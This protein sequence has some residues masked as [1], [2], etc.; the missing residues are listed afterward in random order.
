M[1]SN[2]PD[3]GGN[4]MKTLLAVL[5]AAA[6]AAGCASQNGLEK[7]K[8]ERVLAKYEPFVGEPVN[9]FTAFRQHS[10]QP[11][12]R[13]QLILWTSINDAYLLSVSN[14][15]PD[16]MF[17]NAV[18]VSSTGS[19]ISTHDFVNVRGDRC[20]IEK[21]QPIDVRAWRRDRDAREAA[22]S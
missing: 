1:A 8:G 19:S 15:C 9:S 4:A 20:R 12:S 18:S 10:W 13:S 11:V 2:P 3:T 22:A 5:V 6:L 17:A 16:M 14:N 21:I 7:S